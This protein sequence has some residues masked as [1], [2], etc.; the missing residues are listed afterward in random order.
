MNPRLALA[1]TAGKAAG[2][3]VRRMGRGGGTALPGLV[4]ER[5]D[6]G[7]VGHLAGQLA[8]GRVTISGTNGK[9]TTSPVP[10]SFPPAAGA[11]FV[12]NREGSNLMRGLASTLLGAASASGAIPGARASYGLFEV[13]EATLPLA[14]PHLRPT[15]LGFTNLF[16]DQLDRYGEVDTV[17]SLWR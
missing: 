1:V 7:L 5:V 6:P 16:R 17:F 12:H 2:L 13:D 9:A 11:P 10:A 14:M 4:A 15:V 8:G 3:A